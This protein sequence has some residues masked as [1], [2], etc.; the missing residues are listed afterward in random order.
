MLRVL[1]CDDDPLFA[2]SLQASL[3][4]LFQKHDVE[5]KIHTYT[6]WEDVGTIILSSYDIA[7]LDIDF[8]GYQYTGIDIARKLRS[9]RQD[10]II[11]FVTNY[12][13]FAPEG[14][15]VQAFRYLLKSELGHKLE[16]TLALALNHFNSVR[17][18]LKIQSNGE[19]IDILLS[20]ILF[21]ESQGHLLIIHLQTKTGEKTVRQYSIYASLSSFEKKLDNYGFLRIHK[22]YL[23]NMQ[24]IKK[25]QCT[26]A[27][28]SDGTTLRVSEK[29][30]SEQKKKY[31]LWRSR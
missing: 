6:C 10:S 2:K 12:I 27:V 28:L 23:V 25:Y 21:V 13:E 18:T 30:Y 8:S 7:F 19:L 16:K 22:S 26:E 5:A 31:L 1:I 3:T 29:N 9:V 20:D 24:H 14:Y 15:E 17:E 4:A 11:I